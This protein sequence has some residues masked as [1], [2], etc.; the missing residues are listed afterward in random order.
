MTVDCIAYHA[1]TRPEA[2]A[3]IHDGRR[4][5]YA[6]FHR[7]I[8]RFVQAAQEFGLSPGGSVAVECSDFYSHW[9]LLLAFERLGI[10]TASLAVRED[11]ASASQLLPM[12]D[13]VLSETVMP[14][15]RYEP[16]TPAWLQ[17]AFAPVPREAEPRMPRSPDDVVRILRTSGTTGTS[18]RMLLRRRVHEA[19][20]AKWTCFGIAREHRYLVSMPFTMHAV[21]SMATAYIRAGATV[22]HDA[23]RELA[24]AL[25]AFDIDHVILMPKQLRHVLDRLPADSARPRNLVISSLGATLPPPLRKRAL[26]RIATAV[27]DMYACNEVALVA[28]TGVDGGTAHGTLWPGVGVEIV[29]ERENPLPHG[30]AGMIRIGTDSMVE[31]YLDDPETTARMFLDEWFYP[32]DVGILHGARQLQVVGRADELVNVGGEKISPASVEELILAEARLDDVGVCSVPD[33]EGVEQL[34]I[35]VPSEVASGPQALARVAGLVRHVRVG[36]VFVVAVPRIPRTE[37]GKIQ[38]TLL[39]AAALEAIKLARAV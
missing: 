1:L 3:V 2:V 16:L 10:A 17:H 8:L 11:F 5:T 28:V 6:D 37:T 30:Q 35:A 21:Y 39:K 12:M 36:N 4:V 27:L 18:K 33:A 25:T 15:K 14:G 7:D 20:L 29:D 24:E 9:L 23:K 13:L 26:S 19:R 22:V 31:G 32:G 38:R 34:C